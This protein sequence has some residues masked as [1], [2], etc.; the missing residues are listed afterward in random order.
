MDP[1]DTALDLLLSTQAQEVPFEDIL[2]GTDFPPPP[3]YTCQNPGIYPQM[4]IWAGKFE[5]PCIIVVAD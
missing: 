5:Y 1:I 4:D 2:L 3:G